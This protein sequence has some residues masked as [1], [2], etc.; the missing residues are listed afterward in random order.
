MAKIQNVLQKR[1]KSSPNTVA[2]VRE[3]AQSSGSGKRSSFEG[4]FQSEKLSEEEQAKLQSL[5]EKYQTKK[6][7][8][9]QDFEELSQLCIEVKAITKQAII[10]HGE[11]IAKAQVVL[12]SYKEGAFSAW[13]SHTYGNRQTPYNLL[14]YYSLWKQ[15][16]EKERLLM[17]QIPRQ[18]IYTLA[19]RD[20]DIKKKLEFIKAYGGQSKQQL[21][22]LI[23]HEFPLNDKDRRQGTHSIL[24]NARMLLRTLNDPSMIPISQAQARESLALL[25]QVQL[26]L[27]KHTNL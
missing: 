27:N 18:A 9:S 16:T 10:L 8:V 24:R 21:L 15:L 23:R 17:E 6:S 25:R 13:L 11:R 12:K 5:L 20:V 22:E 4:V 2:K 7:N 3:L 26:L 14:Q 1:L 19:S